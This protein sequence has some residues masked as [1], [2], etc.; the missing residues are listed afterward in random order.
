MQAAVLLYIAEMLQEG[1]Q[2]IDIC[3][4]L[5]IIFPKQAKDF[6][7]MALGF[8]NGHHFYELVG[9]MKIKG[10]IVY[11]IKVAESFGQFGNGLEEIAKY[12][13]EQD[14]HMRRMRSVMIYP[15]MLML[16]M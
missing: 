1:F 15:I 12:I 9:F 13:Q 3:R 4:F 2:L 10:N 14:V 16:L 11:Q 6:E 7:K 5:I 8:E